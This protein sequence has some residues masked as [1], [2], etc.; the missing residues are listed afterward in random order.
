[1]APILENS[2]LRIEINPTTGDI[3]SLFNK[4]TG[5]EYL[6]LRHL[7]RAFRLY[8]PL[9]LRVSGLFTDP[10]GHALESWA[11]ETCEIQTHR[12]DGMTKLTVS[13]PSLKSEA[14]LFPIN[15]IYTMELADDSDEVMLHL[16]VVN[17]SPH[18]INEVFFPWLGGFSEI[19]DIATDTLVYPNRIV[20]VRDAF[21]VA[22]SGNWEEHPYL[23]GI[24]GIPPAWP[25]GYDLAMPWLNFGGAGEGLYLASLDRTGKRH[26]LIVQDLSAGHKNDQ[27][28]LSIAWNFLAYVAP[29]TQWTSPPIVVSLHRGD[30]HVAADKYRRS[31]REWYQIP[32]PPRAFQKV[33]G[34]FNS[35]FTRRDFGQIADLAADIRQYGLTDLI[36]WYFGN[37]YPNILEDDD[38][39]EGVSRLGLVSSHYG[40]IERLRAAN[41]RA[42]A[43]GVRT[44]II[45]SQRLWNAATLTPELSKLAEE[46]VIRRETGVPAVEA[47][48]HHHYGGIQWNHHFSLSEYV[49]CC[50]C[51]GWQEFAI[52]NIVEV[53]KRA[54]Y[55]TLFYDQAVETEACFHP[56]HHHQDVSA[57]SQ[58]SLPFLFRLKAELLRANPDAILIGEGIELLSSQVLD[59]GWCWTFRRDGLNTRGPSNPEVMRYTL[60]W[61]RFAMPLDDDIETANQWFVLGMH[62]AIVPRSLESGKTLSEFPEFAAHISR[63]VKLYD[64]LESFLIDGRFMD[65]VGLSIE[66]AFAR[67]YLTDTQ[68][69]VVIANLGDKSATCRFTLDTDFYGVTDPGYCWHSIEDTDSPRYHETSVQLHPCEVGAAVFERSAE[70]RIALW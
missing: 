42:A 44:G 53:L 61:Y 20:R 14:G 49:M 32:H 47:W 63:L 52:A 35:A 23:P 34:S 25:S 65:T 5:R 15:V 12:M 13:Y 24:Q 56:A 10:T 46:W 68:V 59:L 2:K 31:L 17:E 45:F 8:T 29:D 19:E 69:A 64:Q 22:Q 16:T 4:Q 70:R 43:L 48:N 40:G 39:S 11:Q 51:A 6:L 3:V 9:P 27:T 26:I 18:T 55:T 50:A 28:A 36:L 1:M 38:I 58:A 37:Y 21:P 66:G 62:L 7:A 57:P 54:G 33:L 30:W 60:P 41:A 67:V